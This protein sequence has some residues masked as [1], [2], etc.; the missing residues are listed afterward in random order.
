MTT[1][2]CPDCDGI[3]RAEYDEVWQCNMCSA[4]FYSRPTWLDFYEGEE[5]DGTT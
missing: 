2:K 5:R 1:Y 4:W 3:V